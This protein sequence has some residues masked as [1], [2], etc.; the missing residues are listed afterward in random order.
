MPFVPIV[1]SIAEVVMSGTLAAGGSNAVN[2]ASVFHYR[3][4]VVTAPPT[5]AALET[6]FNGAAGIVAPFLAAANS[7]YTQSGNSVRWINDALDAPVS[8]ARA[9][10]GA[11]ATDGMPTIDSVAMLFRTGMRGK[12][13]RGSKHFPGV[14]ESDTTDDILVGAGLVLWQALQAACAANL[15]DA[16]ANVWTPSVLSRKLSTLA[17]NPTTVV[18]NDVTQVLLNLNVGTMRRRRVSTVR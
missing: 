17:T 3:L 12:S 8:T 10:V 15:T 16:L 13:F 1:G 11:I 9:G 18:A 4:A 7:R 5:K 6:V 14:N 2:V